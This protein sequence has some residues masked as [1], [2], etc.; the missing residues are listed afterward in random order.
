[1]RLPDS[2][3]KTAVMPFFTAR[4]PVRNGNVSEAILRSKAAAC[5]ESRGLIPGTTLYG[6]GLGGSIDLMPKF[7]F[8]EEYWAGR[9][10]RVRGRRDGGEARRVD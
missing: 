7:R 8:C 10:R 5:V 2:T 3:S 1:M 4:A 6:F 9:R